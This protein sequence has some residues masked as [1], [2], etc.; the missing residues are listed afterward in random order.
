M[1]TARGTQLRSEVK[2]KCRTLVPVLYGLYDATQ[3]PDQQETRDKVARLLDGNTFIFKDPFTRSGAYMHPIIQSVINEMWFANKNDEGVVYSE[4]FEVDVTSTRRGSAKRIGI[5][6][7]TITLVLTAV[8]CALEE[9][10]SGQRND[11][12]FTEAAYGQKFEDNLKE[13]DTFDQK[14]KDQE[15]I[16]R[17]QGNLLKRARAYAKAPMENP[18]QMAL[19]EDDY[20]AAIRDW[21][22]N[23]GGYDS[24]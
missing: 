8:Q 2:S 11:I 9:W 18:H 14:T 16:P 1:I 3:K 20:E 4:Y 17:I 15:I 13:L 19:Q 23:G 6:L 22:V 7:V 10:V 12:Q 21:E 5:P 24:E